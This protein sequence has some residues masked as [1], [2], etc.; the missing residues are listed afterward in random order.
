MSHSIIT[1]LIL[2]AVCYTGVLTSV[3]I[4]LFAGIRRARREERKLTSSGLRR[5]VDK[6]TSYYSALFALTGVDAMLVAAA[7]GIKACGGQG[8]LPFPYL[9]VLGAVGEAL[10]E[11][12]SVLENIEYKPDLAATLR[13]LKRLLAGT[14]PHSSGR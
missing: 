1:C 10:I 8:F 6:L 5:T 2:L 14:N 3:L 11:V 12:K 9:S 13:L 7:L 4:D